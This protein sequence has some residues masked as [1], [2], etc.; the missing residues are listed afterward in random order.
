[1]FC[2]CI[3]L[4]LLILNI[5]V[6]QCASFPYCL[7]W[8]HQYEDVTE[9]SRSVFPLH[10]QKQ[11]NLCSPYYYVIII[12][13]WIIMMAFFRF[14]KHLAN[15]IINTIHSPIENWSRAFSWKFNIFLRRTHFGRFMN[16][17]LYRNEYMEGK[18]HMLINHRI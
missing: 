9:L 7:R 4:I 5:D 6:Q 18:N 12:E 1:M 3:Q 10:E 2:S 8:A 13:Y 16:I 15:T 14:Q 11:R 17:S